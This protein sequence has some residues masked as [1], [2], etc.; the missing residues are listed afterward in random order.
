MV[1]HT[2]TN[3]EKTTKLLLHMKV[4]INSILL[5]TV[6]ITGPVQQQKLSATVAKESRTTI[7]DFEE[8]PGTESNADVHC[9]IQDFPPVKQSR[10]GT[11]YFDGQVSDGKK[12]IRVVGF[13]EQFSA[14]EAINI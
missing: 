6:I 10:L 2:P 1:S 3:T 8:I 7:S 5:L 12:S 14:I 13:D 4:N 9:I 11:T